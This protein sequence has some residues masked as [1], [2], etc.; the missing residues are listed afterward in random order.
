MYAGV[1]EFVQA[2]NAE[3][4]QS[5]GR[6]EQLRALVTIIAELAVARVD[7]DELGIAANALS[8][9]SGAARLFSPWRDRSK[10]TVFGS[11]RIKPD[12]ALY[13]MA[14][15]LGQRMAGRGWMTVSGAGPGIME[16][17]AKGAGREHTLGVNVD[18][19]FEQSANPYVDAETRL[20]EMKYFF[21]R[22]VALTR[23]SLAFAFFPGGLGTM[24]EAFE[25]LT[26]LHTGKTTPSPVVLIDTEEGRYWEKWLHFMSEAVIADG[27]LDEQSPC[28]FQICHS[29]DD[30]IAVIDRFYANFE[31]FRVTNSH[32]EVVLRHPPTSD[33]VATLA[34]A[35]PTFA[36]G[37]GY[38]CDGS[39]VRFPFD[40]RNYVSVRRVIDEMNLWVG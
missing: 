26:L 18:L 24:D 16:A 15:E 3:S 32:A 39:T 30:A 37:D 6:L 28:L 22:K 17:A 10:L 38:R 11:A 13:E 34:R 21:T 29:L 2:L 5:E 9:L 33:Q 35:V 31:S 1:E 20:I 25:V 19:P 36:Y 8:E 14:R 40:G 23:E 27:Y 7:R 12:S 4:P